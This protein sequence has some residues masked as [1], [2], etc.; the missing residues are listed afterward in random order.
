M[1]T[2]NCKH[3]SAKRAFHKRWIAPAVLI[4]VCLCVFSWPFPSCAAPFSFDD[5]KYWVGSGT[6]RAALVIDWDDNSLQP[7]ALAWGY[8]WN[9]TARGSDM[10]FAIVAADAR[11]F[12]KLGGSDGNPN[13]LYGVGYDANNNREFGV[14][15]GT[16]FD[17]RGIAFTDP[18]DLASATDPGDYYA[19]G[20]FAGFWHYG[21]ATADPYDAGSWSDTNLGMASRTLTDGAWDSWTFTPSFSF[22][23]FAENPTAAEPPSPGDFN[24]DGHVDS[25]DYDVWRSTF[26]STSQ[27]AADANRN[28]VVDAADYVVW[29]RAASVAGSSNSARLVSVPEPPLYS[30]AVL[31]FCVGFLWSADGRRL[32]QMK[33]GPALIS[34]CRRFVHLDVRRIV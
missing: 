14:N 18:S 32:A 11:L 29:R 16:V 3:Q 7:P 1:K 21:V 8:R 33:K 25:A 10:L 15:D 31:A 4:F 5:I 26:G 19:E 30:L 12:A 27:L 17:S 34:V 28:A 22:S 9:G 23:A 20:W 24:H 6:N 2:K 13:A